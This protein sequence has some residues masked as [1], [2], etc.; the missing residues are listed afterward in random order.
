M[1]TAPGSPVRPVRRTGPGRRPDRQDRPEGRVGLQVCSDPLRPRRPGGTRF[2]DVTSGRIIRSKPARIERILLFV[3]LADGGA[4]PG[5][6]G[7]DSVAG[8]GQEADQDQENGQAPQPVAGPGLFLSKLR[9]FKVLIS[10]NSEAI[11]IK[12]DFISIFSLFN[13]FKTS[14]YSSILRDRKSV[15]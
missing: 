9:R 15:V 11:I 5:G 14:K 8:G 1:S 7:E 3:L 4:G 13:T 2:G 10:I 6:G 12:S